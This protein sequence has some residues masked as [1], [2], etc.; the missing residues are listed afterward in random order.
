M[1]LLFASGFAPTSGTATFANVSFTG[2][3]NQT[4]GAN[5]ITRGIYLNH[6]LTAV[7]DYRALE[8]SANSAN[9][10]AIYQS[11]STATNN[12]VGRTSFGTTSAPNASALIDMV[13]TSLGFGL[14]AMTSTQRDAI[15]SPRQGLIVYDTTNDT[16][17]YRDTSAWRS[18]SSV[19]INAQTGT[20]YTL[21]LADAGKLVTLD[22]TSAITLTVPTNAS[23]AFPIGTVI[24]ICRKNTGT[25]T[26]SSS[27]TINSADGDMKLRVRYS[28]ATL[29]KIGT[30]EWLLAGDISA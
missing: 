14:P 27:A 20:T 8:I 5:G 29:T 19:A 13:S 12:I 1:P 15:S 7:A 18:L 25:V 11:G 21:V 4:G 2:T 24:D 9:S 17:S 22:N 28:C 10:K 23:V 6:T 30:D 26:L 16:I 3:L